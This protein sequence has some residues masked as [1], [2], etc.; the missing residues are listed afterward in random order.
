MAR[1]VITGTGTDVGKTVFA[2]GLCGL[3]GADYW[4]PVQSGLA[5]NIPNPGRTGHAPDMHS[6]STARTQLT[7]VAPQ[8]LPRPDTDAAEVARLSGAQV[9]PEAWLLREPLSPHRAAELEG[10][11]VDPGTLTPPDI[12]PLVIEGAG[13]VLVPVTRKVLFAD[14]FAEWQIPVILV[15]TTGLGTISHSLTALESLR[16]RQVPVHGVAFVGDENRDNVATIG[17][18]GAVKVLGRL[19]R[20]TRLDRDS[21]SRAMAENFDPED[22]R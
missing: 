19:P 3:I 14:L 18:L 12:D 8:H 20:V 4:K 6:T 2:A 21:L 17:Q 10:I 9:H 5:G 7:R 13:G 22:Y 11:E 15:A 16:A 1:F